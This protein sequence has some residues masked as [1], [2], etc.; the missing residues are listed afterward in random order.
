MSEN[1]ITVSQLNH[2]I[3]RVLGTDPLLARIVVVGE[4][5][6]VKIHSSK[7]IYFTLKDKGSRVNCFFPRYNV[8]KAEFIPEDG[9]EILVKGQVSVYEA[10]GSYSINVAQIEKS[11]EGDLAAA[12]QQLK[13]KLKKE[14]LFDSEYKKPLPFFPRNIAIITSET[15]AVLHDILSIIKSKNSA[16][17]LRIFPSLVQGEQ[18]APN[19]I[20]TIK[21]VNK[22]FPETDLIILGRG[23]G[24]LED[25]WAFNDEGLARTIFESLIPIISAVGHETDFTISDFVADVRAET[26][27]AAANL[28]VPDTED[29]KEKIERLKTQLYNSGESILKTSYLEVKSHDLNNLYK[30]LTERIK[31]TEVNLEQQKQQL[32]RDMDNL[33]TQNQIKIDELYNE[34]DIVEKLNRAI[35]KVENNLDKIIERTDNYIK[36]KKLLIDNTLKTIEDLSPYNV[37]KRGYA[38]VIN[39]RGKA[40]TTIKQIKEKDS[41]SLVFKDGEANAVV[42][43]VKE[44]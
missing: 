30:I 20:K 38:I 10:G 22:E 41:L 12:F 2:Y 1:P 27:T 33:I 32:T 16:C 29:L 24:S 39:P 31:N 18:A 9:M 35:V 13:E 37:M 6:G 4:V 43:C 19:L 42:E 26:P 34:L 23:G 44:K 36:S 11:G 17:N 28:S 8:A 5:S 14:G 21:T 40:I 3:S 25:L 7:H 15:G